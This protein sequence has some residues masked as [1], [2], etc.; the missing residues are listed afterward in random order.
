MESHLLDLL[1][2]SLCSSESR[3]GLPPRHRLGW[4]QCR[5]ILGGTGERRGASGVYL[6]IVTCCFAG[7]LLC[8]P[9]V[10]V[11]QEKGYDLTIPFSRLVHFPQPDDIQATSDNT[12]VTSVDGQLS[13]DPKGKEVWKPWKDDPPSSPCIH[14]QNR[15]G[16]GIASVRLV[17]FPCS[18]NTWLRY[19]IESATGVFTGAVYNDK[20]LYKGGYRG[21]LQDPNNGKTVLQKTHASTFLT[22][23]YLS[24]FKKRY[25]SMEPFYPAVLLVRNPACAIISFHKLRVS[26]SHTG[27]INKQHFHDE[28]FHKNF[29]IWLCNW[30]A[31][32]L[33]RLLGSRAPVFVV[34][35]EE[36]V[37]RPLHTL[38]QVLTFLGTPVDEGRMSCLEA[39]LEGKFKREGSKQIDPYTT[40]EK[41]YIAA[42]TYKVNNTLQMLGYAP[43]P[44][45]PHLD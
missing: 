27:Q 42:A 19:L 3:A 21:E 35:Y 26:K 6:P 23:P 38:R 33:D 41:N 12:H 8:G 20:R 4:R 24:D 25:S 44:T 5:V 31:L 17:S 2:T 32:V 15:L 14:Y 7:V 39:H 16:V 30:E 36:L 45:Y 29:N 37:A 22:K 40:E 10:T 18:G 13:L 34:L 28:V 1:L 9:T 43:L 11:N